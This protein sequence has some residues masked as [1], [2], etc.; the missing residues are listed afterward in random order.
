MR[1]AEPSAPW[2]LSVWL[3]CASLVATA[4]V[5]GLYL[6]SDALSAVRLRARARACLRPSAT[7]WSARLESVSDLTVPL[8]G[9]RARRAERKSVALAPS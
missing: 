1:I 6:G 8:R 7:Q 4:A 9:G 2:W 5:L 3:V